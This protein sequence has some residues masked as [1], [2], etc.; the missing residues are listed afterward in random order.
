[1][2]YKLSGQILAGRSATASV[3]TH[4]NLVK[5]FPNENG[6]IFNHC[7]VLDHLKCSTLLSFEKCSAAEFWIAAA[8][9][10]A[11]ILVQILKMTFTILHV[12]YCMI[13]TEKRYWKLVIHKN[14]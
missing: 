1:M 12:I 5:A 2:D 6:L 3:L 13:F 4:L 11:G 9:T 10:D 14:A 8:K 7:R